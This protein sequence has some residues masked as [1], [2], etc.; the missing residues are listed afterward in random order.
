MGLYILSDPVTALPLAVMDAT[1]LTAVRTGAAAAIASKHLARPDARTLGFVGCGAQAPFLPAAHR[2]VY[3]NRLEVLAAD[4]SPEASARFAAEGGG[5]AASITEAAG[6]DIVCTATPSRAPVIARAWV[7]AGAHVNAVGADAH[8]KQELDPAILLDARVVI[9]DWAQATE[10][11]EINVPL[12]EGT[13]RRDH[14]HG[15]LGEIVAGRR[16]GREDAAITVFDSTG[17]A[18][19]DVALARVVYAAAREA[20]AG[21]ELDFLA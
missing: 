7:R 19:Q 12:H 17:L 14:I 11:G 2:A 16:P 10:S 1:R 9:D 21:V 15:T 4:A 8:G 20:G 3:G 5:C 13:L 6:C 18:L